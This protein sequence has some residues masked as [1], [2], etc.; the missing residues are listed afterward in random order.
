M[1]IRPGIKGNVPSLLMIEAMLVGLYNPPP[2]A[3][4]KVIVHSLSIRTAN[5]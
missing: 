3:E 4:L 1:A 5:T 2:Y